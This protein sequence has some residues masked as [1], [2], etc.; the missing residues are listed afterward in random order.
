MNDL[1]LDLRYALRTLRANPGFTAVATLTLALGLGATTAIYTV[2]DQVLLRPLPYP[3]AER[4]VRVWHLNPRSVAPREGMAYETYGE[5]VTEVPALAAAAGVSPEW[6]FT[7]R[8]PQPERATGYWVSAS[9]FDLLGAPALGRGFGP[10]EDQPGGEPVVVLSHAYWRRKFSGDSTIVGRTISVG[11]APATVLGVMP[12]GFRYGAAVDLFAP[13]G[14]NPIVPR[15]RQVRWVDAVARLAPGATVDQARRD[16]AM[17]AGRLARAYPAEAGG[18]GGDV[19]SLADATVGGVR[20]ALWT[21]LG[22]VGFVLLIACANIGN[23]LLARATARRGEIAV[24]SA[25]GAS[26][27]RL[28]RQ[29]LTESGVLAV[30][31]GTLG[32]L[33]A[34]WLLSLLRS[35]GPADL[36]RLDQVTLDARVLAVSALITLGAGFA[37]GLAP[38]VDAVRTSLQRGLR[39]GG[40]TGGA[41]GRLRAGLVVAEVT[42]AVMLLAGAG[43]LI[44]SFAELM[45]VDPGFRA[46][47]VLTFQMAIPDGYDAPGRNALLDRV[48]GELGAIPGV[49][50]V[51]STTRLPLGSNLSTK[52]DVRD[53]PMPAGEAH[54]VEFRRAGGDYFA[55]LGI[56]VVT[57]RAFDQRDTPPA[58]GVMI[59]NR[60]LAERLWPGEDP[61]GKD[62]RFWYAGMPPDAPWLSIVGVVGDVKH[63]GLDAAA[64]DIAYFAASQGPPTNPLL[65]VRTAGT[66]ELLVAPVRERLRVIDPELL[67]YDVRPME[68]M[69]HASVAGR[70]FTMLLLGLFGTLALTLAAVGIYGVIGYAVRRRT[71]ELGIRVALGAAR[72]D[73]LRLVVGSGMRLAG[74]GLALGLGAALVLTRFMRSLL[75]AVSPTDPIALGAVALL[76]AAVAFV[77]TLLPARRAARVNPTAALRTE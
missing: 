12:A 6:S 31:G 41:G 47:R 8:A 24:R 35:L 43:L 45:R 64:P 14:Q 55:A 4:L 23:L 28:V 69:V 56:P 57:G 17:F 44:R 11:G 63:F 7:V 40:R 38:A 36:P 16:V 30:V 1:L 51:G 72:A 3:Q 42:L 20:P 19:A 65:A 46:D 10:A 58:P 77:A 67:V 21:L 70:R 9:F 74:L 29:L 13:L 66:P 73:V 39:E 15:G 26:G 5:L 62:V 32:V 49:E 27:G 33:L 76:L 61:I 53:R 75:F 48:Y 34:V 37:F 71:R 68:A 59:I 50:A 18:L 52:L 60:S 25:L 54:E 22:G 2:V